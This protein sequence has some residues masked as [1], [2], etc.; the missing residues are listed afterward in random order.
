MRRSRVLG[1]EDG[2]A[3]GLG[4]PRHRKSGGG[5]QRRQQEIRA[6]L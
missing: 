6:Q 2:K 5:S 4:G 3:H 1:A